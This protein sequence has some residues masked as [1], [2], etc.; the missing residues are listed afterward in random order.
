VER[1]DIARSQ[2]DDCSRHEVLRCL[3]YRYAIQLIK[4]DSS[5]IFP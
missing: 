5:G 1:D 2:S 3:V 4:P